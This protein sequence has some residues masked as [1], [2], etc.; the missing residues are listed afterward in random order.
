LLVLALVRYRV[1]FVRLNLR[2][3]KDGLV[4]PWLTAVTAQRENNGLCAPLSR[5]TPALTACRSGRTYSVRASAGFK[6]SIAPR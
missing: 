6:V 4:A 5:M 1:K 3:I 2:Q